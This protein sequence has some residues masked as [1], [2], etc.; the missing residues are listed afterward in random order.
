MARIEY[1]SLETRQ[2]TL[3]QYQPGGVLGYGATNIFWRQIQNFIIDMTALP[4]SAAIAGI[5][6]PTGQAT[7]LQNI[8]VNMSTASGTKH[9]GVVIEN[10]SGGLLADIIFNGGYQAAYFGNQYV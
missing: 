8:V 1:L 4:A 10:G 9:Q 3:L 7:S 6:W 2:L 5:H